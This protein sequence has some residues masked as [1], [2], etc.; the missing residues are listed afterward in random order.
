M[1]EYAV[2][3]TR[4]LH[5]LPESV[6]VCD[7]A[8]LEPVAVSYNT[9]FAEGTVNPGDVVVILGC[10]P[11]GILCG[12]LAVAA[13]A[14][15]FLTG[16]DGN[17]FRLD[18]ARAAGVQHVVNVSS[19]D[20]AALV[21]QHVGPDGPDLIVDA[22]GGTDSFGQAMQM[23]GMCGTI[24]KVGWFHAPG[25]VPLNAMVAKNLRI[26]GVYGH[27]YPVWEKSVKSL[28]MGHIPLEH[29]VTHRLPLEEWEK[30]FQLM[31][32]RKA[33]KVLLQP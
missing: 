5:R 24:V 11:I 30:G 28:A 6:Y 13:G 8:I 25:N 10:G 1:A 26:H 4:G 18:K 29:I 3:P 9:L 20:V 27:T 16:R 21:R 32:E 33:V 15:V 2:V 7:A 19:Q 12:S 31:E 22:T 17:E 23:A 14:E